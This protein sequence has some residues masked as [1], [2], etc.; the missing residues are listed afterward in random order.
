[1]QHYLT[2]P[3]RHADEP[4]TLGAGSTK[5][6]TDPI[7]DLQAWEVQPTTW[8]RATEGLEVPQ[9]QPSSDN[10]MER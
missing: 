1:M 2:S 7:L 3:L 10:E 8:E 4:R 6:R 5:S 9:R